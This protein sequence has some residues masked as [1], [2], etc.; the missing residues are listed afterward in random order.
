MIPYTFFSSERCTA[1]EYCLNSH[2]VIPYPFCHA[3]NNTGRCTKPDCR[4]N[5]QLFEYHPPSAVAAA[6]VECL[7]RRTATSQM[8]NDNNKRPAYGKKL[9]LIHC[10]PRVA[11]YVALLRFQT[12]TV[13]NQRKRQQ[14]SADTVL[15]PSLPLSTLRLHLLHQRV[16]MV[17]QQS[18]KRQPTTATS[19][20][21]PAKSRLLHCP[22]ARPEVY[23]EYLLVDP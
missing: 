23:P 21:H 1:G 12:T 4:F 10:L 9:S 8:L 7:R 2:D 19:C 3:F 6:H 14:C 15:R 17:R 11:T 13:R 5:H 18:Q 16:T 20:H 22:L